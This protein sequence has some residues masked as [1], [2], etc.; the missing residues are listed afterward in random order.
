ML[1]KDRHPIQFANINA[2]DTTLYVYHMYNSWV[3]LY[4][5]RHWYLPSTANQWVKSFVG[6]RGRNIWC[7]NQVETCYV[8]NTYLDSDWFSSILHI[9]W[10]IYSWSARC[11]NCVNQTKAFCFSNG[12]RLY[13]FDY[14]HCFPQSR[15]STSL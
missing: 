6:D 13:C 1:A 8:H 4:K 9:V 10:V 2:Y 7:I 11:S 15:P 3:E 12:G 14:H 5:I